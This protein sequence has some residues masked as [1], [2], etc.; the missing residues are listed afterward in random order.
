MTPRNIR[1][2]AERRAN[3]LARKF[4]GPSPSP[5]RPLAPENAA[6]ENQYRLLQ[7][8]AE[9]PASGITVRQTAPPMATAAAANAA[10]TAVISP[11]TGHAI[12]LPATDSTQYSELLQAYQTQFQPVGL[13]ESTLVQSLADT[14]WRVR[15]LLAL[16]MAIFAKGRIDFAD[17]FAGHDPALRVPLIEVQTFLTYEK[18]IRVLQLQEARLT[19]R[20]GKESAELNR[21]QQER[22]EREDLDRE[23]KLEAASQLHL[24]AQ[25]GQQ[26]SHPAENGFEYSNPE[27]ESYLARKQSANSRLSASHTFKRRAEAA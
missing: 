24:A 7:E 3:K 16:E 4:A 20:A 19:R 21:L 25:N 9:A 23:C 11:L 1:R 13:Q 26:P 18:Q 10:L 15:R 22:R 12:V 6:I 17:Q 27:T 8:N 5:D 14:A 2:A